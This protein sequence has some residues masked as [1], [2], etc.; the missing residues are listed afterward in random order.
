[1]KRWLYRHTLRKILFCT[2]HIYINYHD[3]W[4]IDLTSLRSPFVLLSIFNAS[5]FFF[6]VGTFC[7]IPVILHPFFSSPIIHPLCD[8]LN[9]IHFGFYIL[10]S[11]HGWAQTYT[12][13]S[14]F[15][16][17]TTDFHKPLM[18]IL[19]CCQRCF[20]QGTLGF[21]RGGWR[22]L[23]TLICKGRACCLWSRLRWQSSALPC[24]HESTMPA[25]M[26]ENRLMC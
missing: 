16:L 1:M 12:C 15:R 9:L 6:P 8:F 5:F 26:T 21:L 7:L 19:F 17:S 20:D 25:E 2:A 3:V 14:I 13:F 4:L 24:G 10:V 23:W 11:V 18:N 22:V